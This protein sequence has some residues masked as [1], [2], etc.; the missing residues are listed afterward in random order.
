MGKMSFTGSCLPW[1]TYCTMTTFLSLRKHWPLIGIGLLGILV[2]VHL[3]RAPRQTTGSSSGTGAALEKGLKLEDI[4]YSQD[5]PDDRVKWFLDAK[6]A[7]F[8][9]DKQVVSFRN[10]KLRLEPENRPRVELEG[11]KGAFTGPFF[12]L[13]GRGLLLNVEKETLLIPSD[14]TALIDKGLPAL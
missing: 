2:S 13:E 14:V 1:Y 5:D 10:F 6:E 11:E 8:S 3:S 7:I 12:S 9:D 4:H